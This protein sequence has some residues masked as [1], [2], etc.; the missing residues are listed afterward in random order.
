MTKGD[1]SAK[2]LQGML[3]H[4]IS[5]GLTV[6]IF[7]GIF[8][9]PASRIK[10]FIISIIRSSLL[11]RNLGDIDLFMEFI[12]IDKMITQIIEKKLCW[13]ASQFMEDASS[14]KFDLCPTGTEPDSILKAHNI[15]SRSNVVLRD[16]PE[17][18]DNFKKECI[19]TMKCRFSKCPYT[20]KVFANFEKE[21][22]IDKCY[23]GYLNSYIKFFVPVSTD[24]TATNMKMCIKKAICSQEVED[25]E[26]S[27]KLS[28]LGF[29]TGPLSKFRAEV[30]EVQKSAKMCGNNS[31]T[32]ETDITQVCTAVNNDASNEKEDADHLK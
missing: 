2:D 20:Q 23:L 21:Q 26:T 13:S 24:T 16:I 29:N 7:K 31:S 1:R 3:A 14:Y 32:S 25:S 10:A 27:K 12:G 6:S 30:S 22:L 9:K 5:Q 19:C 4:D 15:I 18:D 17:P 11:G 28:A 8:R